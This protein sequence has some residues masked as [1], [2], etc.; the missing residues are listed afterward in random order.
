MKKQFKFPLSFHEIGKILGKEHDVT[1]DIEGIIMVK[2]SSFKD[3]ATLKS[4]I[5]EQIFKNTFDYWKVNR[6]GGLVVGKDKLLCS[7]HVENFS[8]IEKADSIN[9]MTVIHSQA[10]ISITADPGYTS[11]IQIERK[12]QKEEEKLTALLNKK[13]YSI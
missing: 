11:E 5:E 3:D 7:T 9:Q 10:K 1:Q 8:I 13:K 2:K 12:T 6:F 4:A